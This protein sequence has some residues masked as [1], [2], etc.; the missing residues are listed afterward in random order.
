MPKSKPL[1]IKNQIDLPLQV[2]RGRGRPRKA[3]SLSNAERQRRWRQK[4]VTVKV[5]VL[6][7]ALAPTQAAVLNVSPGT[8]SFWSEN[9]RLRAR[10][11]E[12]EDDLFRRKAE[13]AAARKMLGL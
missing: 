9:D 4:T 12:L 10:I 8:D 1:D 6:E 13:L 5:D 3:D 7:A 2:K 11:Q